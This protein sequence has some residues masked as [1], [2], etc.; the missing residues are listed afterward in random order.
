MFPDVLQ[1][2]TKLYFDHVQ[3]YD[4]L[5]LKPVAEVNVDILQNVCYLL[6]HWC[7]LES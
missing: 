2:K 4:T 1:G 5:H 6:L 7:S 3:C